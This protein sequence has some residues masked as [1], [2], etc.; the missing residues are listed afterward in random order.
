MVQEDVW[1]YVL[2]EV[3]HYL[4]HMVRRICCYMMMHNYPIKTINILSNK[5]YKKFQKTSK[6]DKICEFFIHI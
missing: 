2:K 4:H 1:I 6:N 3:R 5:K